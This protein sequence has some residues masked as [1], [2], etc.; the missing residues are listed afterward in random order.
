MCFVFCVC[1]GV[2][3]V[4]FGLFWGLVWVSERFGIHR[5][6]TFIALAFSTFTG[7]Y[8]IDLPILL[9][10]G[11][12]NFVLLISVDP[13]HIRGEVSSGFESAG[14]T[15]LHLISNVACSMMDRNRI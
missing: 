6:I 15:L 13:L 7:V 5:G 2:A 9:I 4:A 10:F 3:C 8:Q 14:W 12:L 11:L 1:F